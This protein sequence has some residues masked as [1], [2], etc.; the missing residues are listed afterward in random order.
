M[1]N[2]G[3]QQTTDSFISSIARD[4]RARRGLGYSARTRPFQ[5]L[6]R[7]LIQASTYKRDIFRSEKHPAALKLKLGCV[8]SATATTKVQPA[9]RYPHERDEYAP[10]FCARRSW[11][12]TYH[13]YR[14][15]SLHKHSIRSKPVQ[16]LSVPCNAVTDRVQLHSIVTFAMRPTTPKQR[17]NKAK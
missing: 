7:P 2:A 13:A 17:D 14:Q 9:Q 15:R 4:H 12:S 5:S 3:A 16:A 1:N 11:F 6:P 10:E 8:T